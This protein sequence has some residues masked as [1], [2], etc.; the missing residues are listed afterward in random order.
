MDLGAQ[1]SVESPFMGIRVARRYHVSGRVQG[2]GY[3]YF[4]QR[5]AIDLGVHGWARNLE[6]GRVEVL[7]LGTAVQLEDFEGE[8]RVGPLR[9]DVRGVVVEEAAAEGIRAGGFHIR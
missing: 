5:V 8:L 6:D 2:V 3:R 1:E 7:A 9:A 4:A